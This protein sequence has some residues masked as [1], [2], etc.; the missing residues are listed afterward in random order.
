MPNTSNVGLRTLSPTYYYC[1]FLVLA[2]K[3]PRA[4]RFPP[5]AKEGF[6]GDFVPG[7]HRWLPD[8]QPYQN[9]G[10]HPFSL[11]ELTANSALCYEGATYFCLTLNQA[12]Q[13][14]F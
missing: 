1:C 8:A 6:R 7:S 12:E 9:F 10:M 11:A 5:L 2:H 4:A 13:Q 3:S 14:E